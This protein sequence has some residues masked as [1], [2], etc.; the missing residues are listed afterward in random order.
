VLYSIPFWL[1]LEVCPP[2]KIDYICLIERSKIYITSL[3]SPLPSSPAPSLHLFWSFFLCAYLIHVFNEVLESS[4][5][6][7]MF[8]RKR[9]SCHARRDDITKKKKQHDAS[10]KHCILSFSANDCVMKCAHDLVGPL[11]QFSKSYV[12]H[13]NILHRRLLTTNNLL[14]NDRWTWEPLFIKCFCVS[15]AF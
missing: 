5:F 11:P 13:I 2:S 8:S 7:S 12:N 9:L 4:K 6:V 14:T 3:P 15:I 10:N 1:I